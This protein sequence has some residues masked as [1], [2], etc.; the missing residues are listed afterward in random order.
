VLAAQWRT[1][2]QPVLFETKASFADGGKDAFFIFSA[3]EHQKL[4]QLLTWI[5]ELLLNGE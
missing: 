5:P 3:P 1:A 4:F 2:F